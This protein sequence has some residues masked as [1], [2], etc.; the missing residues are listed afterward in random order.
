M[1]KLLLT[2]SLLFGSVV[3]KADTISY[4]QLRPTIQPG[5]STSTVSVFNVSSGTVNNLTVSTV[6]ASRVSMSSVTVAN[7]INFTNSSTLANPSIRLPLG[8]GIFNASTMSLRLGCLTEMFSIDTASV[9]ISSNS[10]FGT[11]TVSVYQGTAISS[12]TVNARLQ[13]PG[14]GDSG[15]TPKVAVSTSTDLQDRLNQFAGQIKSGFGLVNWYD[16][17]T[18]NMSSFTITAATSTTATSFI[19][20]TLKVTITPRSATSRIR[21]SAFGTMGNNA[22]SNTFYTITRNSTNLGDSSNG[23]GRTSIAGTFP[24]AISE[25]Y[26][27]PAT[28][29]AVVYTVQIKVDGN[30]GTLAGTGNAVITATEVP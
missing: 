20:T 6:T 13:G 7:Q 25:L 3:A 10:I 18:V 9:N 12:F 19:N 23:F 30:T 27:A 26:D 16:T 1:K 11:G 15:L 24:W 22:L 8:C 29:S 17:P 14:I 28:T 4:I 5:K 2:L 21:I